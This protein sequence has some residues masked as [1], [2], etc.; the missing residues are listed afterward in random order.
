MSTHENIAV[1]SYHVGLG[2]HLG[3]KLIY[4][5]HYRRPLQAS[6]R[7]VTKLASSDHC[8]TSNHVV[9]RIYKTLQET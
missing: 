1:R 4:T 5:R 2:S 9:D 7:L 3:M 6:L 8:V